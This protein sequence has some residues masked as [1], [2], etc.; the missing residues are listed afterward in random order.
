[1]I[2][3]ASKSP[4]RAELLKKIDVEFLLLEAEIEE[5]L[6]LEGSPA[7]NAE[8]L[9]KEKCSQGI[10][11]AIATNLENYP[12]LAA[13]TIVVHEVITGVSVGVW[14]SEKADIATISVSTFVEFGDIS[15]IELKEYSETDEPLDKAGAYAI[16]GYAEKFI[17]GIKGSYSNVVGLPLFE[18]L[19]LLKQFQL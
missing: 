9:A 3:L 16:Q 10:K 12:V 5:N 2:Y 14:G 17:K 11:N 15:A 8:K 1:M 13:D 6:V 7:F 4:R 19:K 18:A